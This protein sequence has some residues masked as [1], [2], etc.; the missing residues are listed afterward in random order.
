M[1]LILILN[2]KSLVNTGSDAYYYDCLIE[3]LPE[4]KRSSYGT[5]GVH[6][7]T[8]SPRLTY[9]STQTN[10]SDEAV[11]KELYMVSLQRPY[12]AFLESKEP[13]SLGL[14]DSLITF[15]EYVCIGFYV[16]MSHG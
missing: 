3:K 1:S 13:L 12:R 15:T 7:Q 5:R 4:E 11:F 6:R 14:N 2:L 16:N 9:I 10:I 8:S